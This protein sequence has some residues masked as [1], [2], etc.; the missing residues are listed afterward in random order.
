M[1]YKVIM[2]DNVCENFNYYFTIKYHANN[3]RNRNKLLKLQWVKLKFVKRLFKY[4]WAILYNDLPK[5]I[6]A[7]ENDPNF[8]KLFNDYVYA[9]TH[10]YSLTIQTMIQISILCKTYVLKFLLFLGHSLY[11]ILDSILKLDFQIVPF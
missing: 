7:C 5:N 9:N 11:K 3:I 1:A 10:K 2:N 8:W 6:R 4:I